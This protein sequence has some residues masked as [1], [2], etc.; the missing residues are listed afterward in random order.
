[1][2]ED[3]AQEEETEE[4]EE[5]DQEG[6]ELDEEPCEGELGLLDHA[7]TS[8]VTDT[9]VLDSDDEVEP[10]AAAIADHK[11]ADADQARPHNLAARAVAT[12][13]NALAGL[14]PLHSQS[15][16]SFGSETSLVDRMAG[17][18]IQ[19]GHENLEDLR[20]RI[21]LGLGWGF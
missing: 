9:L 17:L 20:A 13:Q 14:P 16:Q 21:K 7:Q 10:P 4:E 6:N 18:A 15:Y 2:S 19:S 8:G 11:P 1:M 12:P 5:E 3:E